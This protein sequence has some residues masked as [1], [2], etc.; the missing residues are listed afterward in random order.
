MS[1]SV[2]NISE[3][4][5]PEE[6]ELIKSEELNEVKSLG[7]YLKHKKS[8]ARVALVS[9]EDDNKVFCI[10]FRTP[11]ED[12]TGVAH[13]VEHTTLCGSREFPSK[14]PFVELVKGSLNTFLNAMTYPDK[15]VYPLASQ[16]DK[17]FAN[18]MH[19]YLDAVFYPNFHK[20]KAIFQQ[21]G[22]HFELDE[23]KDTLKYN[24]V[25]Y[26]EMK[27]SFSNPGTI[28]ANAIEAALFPDNT[29]HFVSGGDPDVIPT[30]TYENYLAFH[31]RYY[32]PSNSYIYLYGDFDI[33][34][35]LE[36]LDKHYLSDFTAIDPDSDVAVQKSVSA[37]ISETYAL[38]ADESM[39]HKT[40][41]SYN[42]VTGL[43][44]DIEMTTAMKIL[45]YVMTDAPGA[46]LKQALTDAGIGN[47]ISASYET[48]LKQ[49]VLTIEAA[50]AE[51]EDKDRF[52][53][54]IEDTIK[55]TIKEGISKKSLL[56]AVNYFEFKYREADTGRFPK[57]LLMG[58]RTYDTW[59]YD[60][61]MPFDT[62]EQGGVFAKL[63]DLIDTEYFEK[64]LDRYF[65]KNDH[66]VVLALSPEKGKNEKREQELTEKLKKL[67]S[68]MTEGDIATLK[69][70]SKKLRAFQEN[71]STP[72][73]LAKIPMLSR[74]D[75]S[76]KS[77]QIK[78]KEESAAGIPSLY[79]EVATNGIAYV[80]LLFDV[81]DIAKEDLPY[82]KLLASLFALVDTRKHSYKDFSD[83]ILMHT[84]GLTTDLSSYSDAEDADKTK[85]YF[86]TELKSLV[87]E[88]PKAISLV[89][90]MLFETDFDEKADKRILEVIKEDVSGMQMGL[91]SA[92]N[93][94]AS[95]AAGSLVCATG[96]IAELAGGIAYYRFI[97]D[98]SE[99]FNEKKA[100]LHEKLTVLVK[101]YLVKERLFISFTGSSEMHD[102]MVKE[103]EVLKDSVPSGSKVTGAKLCDVLK[104]EIEKERKE[105]AGKKYGI[106]YTASGRVQYV[107]RVGNYRK[108]GLPYTGM[109][110]FLQVMLSYDYL[111]V[112]IRVK[113][114]AYGCFGMFNRDGSG[115]FTSYRDPGLMETDKVYEGVS[116]YLRNFTADDRTI[117]Q[118]IIGSISDIDQP[119]TPYAEGERGLSMYLR[120]I[121]MDMLEKARAEILD[122]D[123]ASVRKLADYTDAILSEKVLGVVGSE[124]KINE[125]KDYFNEIS[126]LLS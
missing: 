122:A 71:E 95:R 78:N 108:A 110:S 12:S 105:R 37:D 123:E 101:K 34:E 55:K 74:S 124:A 87:S 20:N 97:K 62:I 94:T 77:K 18:L 14:D 100:L 65:I 15:T 104:E 72:E 114:G 17:D 115:A 119:L 13:I 3:V 75:I 68:D 113:G 83:E 5:I 76:T 42:V 73:E 89:N 84:G 32:H 81:A 54:I 63:R 2:K 9:N 125:N 44:T 7:I 102:E 79:H 112:N 109:L 80:H 66:K 91:E 67:R 30:L 52:V 60:D 23:K 24:G 69:V 86:S 6:Y 40:F 98:L 19:V 103:L 117:T 126:S 41:L 46:P 107:A 22:W 47:E 36:F 116:D 121:S 10:G 88:L 120:G 11:P 48:S 96:R 49:P 25:V 111:W 92:G 82:M 61:S 8:G 99:H 4:K 29:Y 90:E 26:N 45:Q 1:K 27:G 70:E 64:L 51:K 56:A 106:A 57:G 53:S 35:R 50:G 93:R 38:G 58:L 85:I 118:Y 39:D 59:L 31:N 28:E 43:S 16:N 21:E 33:E